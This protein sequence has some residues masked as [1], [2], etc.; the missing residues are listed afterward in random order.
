MR[1]NSA[2]PVNKK[3]LKFVELNFFISATVLKTETAAPRSGTYQRDACYCCDRNHKQAAR[4]FAIDTRLSAELVFR[5]APFS[6]SL[7]R[8]WTLPGPPVELARAYNSTR[9]RR[10]L[11]ELTKPSSGSGFRLSTF[12]HSDDPNRK[13][14]LG[15]SSRESWTFG[16]APFCDS[17]HRTK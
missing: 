16:Q 9:T 10:A 13:R 7:D 4:I 2:I 5:T 8:N 1:K 6:K 11:Y 15:R 17:C 3:N 14:V 12:G